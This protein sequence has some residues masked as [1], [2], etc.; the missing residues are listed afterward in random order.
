M[1]TDPQPKLVSSRSVFP[2]MRYFAEA[3][4]R[5][6]RGSARFLCCR[7]RG[8]L[9]DRR[10]QAARRSQQIESLDGRGAAGASREYERLLGLPDQQ[11]PPKRRTWERSAEVNMSTT[12]PS[13]A[14]TFARHSNPKL[15]GPFRTGFASPEA[16]RA[17]RNSARRHDG[18]CGPHR[19]RRAALRISQI[20]L[21]RWLGSAE[22]GAYVFVWAWVLMLGDVASL[23]LGYADAAAHPRVSREARDALCCAVLSA[24]AAS[25]ASPPERWLRRL[26]VGWPLDVRRPNRQPL[27]ACPPTSPSSAFPSPR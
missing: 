14:R 11:L 20:L 2:L 25:P 7:S 23:G 22:Y 21:A 1:S 24:S 9:R 6:A 8:I 5:R 4:G 16:G 19:Q 26:G 17:R 3:D 12:S 15:W 18:L 27:R 10:R 13:P